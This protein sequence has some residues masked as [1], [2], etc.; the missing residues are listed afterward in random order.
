MY[1]DGM[2]QNF[3]EFAESHRGVYATDISYA[4]AYQDEAWVE[5]E[6]RVAARV[7]ITTSRPA[8]EPTLPIWRNVA[9][10]ADY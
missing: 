1:S 10:L 3:A 8:E 9:A 6:D 4:I 2:S 7:R 5:S